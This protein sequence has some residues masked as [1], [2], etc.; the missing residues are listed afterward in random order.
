MGLY[1]NPSNED[2]EESLNSKI[3]VDKSGII[4]Y[5]NEVIS[6]KQKYICIS[7][8]RRFGKTM[9]AEMLTAYYCCGFDSSD[10]FAN[11]K[12]SRVPSYSKHLNKYNVIFLN[13]QEFL[14]ESHNIKDMLEIIKDRVVNDI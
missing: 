4:A 10:M 14:S 9:A 1:L 8:P 2:F 5:S 13:M 7:R 6:T 3:Y 11:L 12:I